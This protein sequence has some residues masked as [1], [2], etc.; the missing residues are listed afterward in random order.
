MG[1][2]LKANLNKFQLQ[3]FKD[4][5]KVTITIYVL[6]IFWATISNQRK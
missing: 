2:G 1:M 4:P 3:V 5:D 6:Q